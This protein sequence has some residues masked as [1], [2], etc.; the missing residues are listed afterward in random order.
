MFMRPTIYLA[1]NYI[2]VTKLTQKHS[3][4]YQYY[5]SVKLFLC[6]QRRHR[7]KWWYKYTHSSLQ[8]LMEASIQ[9]WIFS[10]LPLGSVSML[11]LALLFVI[12]GMRFALQQI[13]VG[14]IFLLSKYKFSVC[15]KTQLPVELDCR[16]I[17]VS[18]PVS[19]WLR[20]NKRSSI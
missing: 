13:K 1:Y 16:P 4:F 18:S 3:I 6:T 2:W 17:I 20:I 19:I 10:S 12:P 8:K 5:I 15:G 14:L 9:F 7:R 11:I